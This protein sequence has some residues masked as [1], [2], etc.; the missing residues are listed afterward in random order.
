[1]DGKLKGFEGQLP[2]MKGGKTITVA[3][4]EVRMKGFIEMRGPIL[5]VGTVMCITIVWFSLLY[6]KD[7]LN[8]VYKY[9]KQFSVDDILSARDDVPIWT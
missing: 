6:D 4:P 9:I 2:T 7:T 5:V 1:M 3:F 8:D